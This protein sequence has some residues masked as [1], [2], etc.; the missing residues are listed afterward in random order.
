[1]GGGRDEGSSETR[2]RLRDV[3]FEGDPVEDAKQKSM[4][5]RPGNRVSEWKVQDEAERLRDRLRSFGHL[6]AEVAARLE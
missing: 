5:L 2:L 1:L 3:R 4:P 6:D